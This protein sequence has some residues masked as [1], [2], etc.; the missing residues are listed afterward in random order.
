VQKISAQRWQRD[1]INKSMCS[2]IIQHV[3]LTADAAMTQP[4]IFLRWRVVLSLSQVRLSR[5]QPLEP[6]TDEL[7]VI[8]IQNIGP[9]LFKRG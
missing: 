2:I 8:N 3:L 5:R 9:F 4:H 1:H 7:T 6:L